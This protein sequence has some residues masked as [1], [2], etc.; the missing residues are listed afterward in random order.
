MLEALK[1][2]FSITSIYFSD[3]NISDDLLSQIDAEIERNEEDPFNKM[4][5]ALSSGADVK[6]IDLSGKNIGDDEA[7]KLVE[8]LKHCLT[9]ERLELGDNDISDDLKERN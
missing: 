5:S 6:A 3:N 8:S 9:L 7:K 1:V 2:N 4:L